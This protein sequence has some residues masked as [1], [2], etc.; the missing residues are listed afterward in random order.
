M[1][2][3][4]YLGGLATGPTHPALLWASTTA[5]GSSEE[6]GLPIVPH[7]T[8]LLV[9]IQNTLMKSSSH[10]QNGAWFHRQI[11]LVVGWDLAGSRTWL[12]H[13]CFQW[14]LNCLPLQSRRGSVKAGQA[15]DGWVCPRQGTKEEVSV[16]ARSCHGRHLPQAH[17]PLK[18]LSLARR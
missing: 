1:K 4:L 3:G 18:S 9:D 12:F 17:C 13:D 14:L 10:S 8:P 5:K 6:L 2:L 16:I 7:P 11:L 15:A